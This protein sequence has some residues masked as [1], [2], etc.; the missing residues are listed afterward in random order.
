MD[1]RPARDPDLDAVAVVVA[2]DLLRERLDEARALRPRADD[3]H[4]ALHHVQELRQLVERRLPD[5]PADPGAAV[6]PLDPAGA[7]S[8]RMVDELAGRGLAAAHRPEL[9]HLEVAA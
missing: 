5:E 9:E 6:R 2:V 1:L 7:D 3:A 4:V 8:R